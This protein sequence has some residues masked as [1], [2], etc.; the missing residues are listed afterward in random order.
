ME[1]QTNTSFR[2]WLGTMEPWQWAQCFDE[3]FR[4]SQMTT[5]L[6][7]GINVVLLKTRHLP[8]SSVFSA[9]FYRL[10]TL[11]PRMGQQQV[12]KMEAG[13]VFVEGIRDAI[14]VNRRMARSMTVERPSVVDPVYHLGPTELISEIDGAITEACAKFGLNVEQFIDEV[15]TIK[16]TL[17]VWENE[18]P[19]LPDLSTWEVPPMTF[20]LVPA[21]RLR[22]NLKGRPQSSR[23]HNE[24]DIREKSDGNLCGVCRLPGHN[25]SKCPLRTTM[26]DNHLNRGYIFVEL[27]AHVVG[28]YDYQHSPRQFEWTWADDGITAIIFGAKYGIQM[29]YTVNNVVILTRVE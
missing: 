5:N 27:D 4:Y 3:G 29:N 16:R 17:R 9:M 11:I 20:E 19:V 18:F 22:R 23:I 12:N 8:I 1:G 28:D 25:R 2:Q 10:A 7:E 13:H 24:M 6:V 15:Y 21:I 26:L 14:V